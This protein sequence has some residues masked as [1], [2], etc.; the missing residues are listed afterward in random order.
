MHTD[1]VWFFLRTY[2]TLRLWDTTLKFAL[3]KKSDFGGKI[4]QIILFF[5][6]QT[7]SWLL[8]FLNSIQEWLIFWQL[9]A[10]A[11]S[12][13]NYFHGPNPTAPQWNRVGW[14]NK[15][16]A[17]LK[18]SVSEGTLCAALGHKRQPISHLRVPGK[19]N[20]PLWVFECSSC[21]QQGRGGSFVHMH[22]L[23][24]SCPRCSPN[25]GP[26][27]QYIT[28]NVSVIIYTFCHNHCPDKPQVAFKPVIFPVSSCACG[29]GQKQALPLK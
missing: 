12:Q 15:A 17:F 4:F 2:S 27:L 24:L 22:L 6:G 1:C 10:S 8:Q 25:L 16:A 20:I 28:L 29:P 23:F 21:W 18:S 3:S 11:I 9:L 13:I 5:R 7:N 14:K 26:V 19:T